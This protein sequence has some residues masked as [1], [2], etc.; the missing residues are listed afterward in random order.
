MEFT[1]VNYKKKQT[2]ETKQIDYFYYTP[3]N[4]KLNFQMF[5][6]YAEK[7]INNMSEDVAD[8]MIVIENMII[9]SPAF[10]NQETKPSINQNKWQAFK[11]KKIPLTSLFMILNKISDENIDQLVEESLQYNNF[12]LQE[13]NQLA[14]VFLGKCIMET[15]NVNVFIKY[16]KAILDNSQWYIKNNDNVFSFRDLMMDTLENE[17]NRLT[18]IA[19]HIEDVYKNQ[20]KDDNMTNELDGSEDYIKKKNIIISLINLIG[21]FYNGHIISTS[22]LVNILE[23]LK[24]Q[25]CENPQY[26]K[27]YLELFLVLWKR[28]NSNLHKHYNDTYNSYNN[29]LIIESNVQCERLKSLIE[30]SLILS[31]LTDEL[32]NIDHENCSFYEIP[33]ELN[34]MLATMN[35]SKLTKYSESVVQK[36][37]I[38]YLLEECNNNHTMLST[39]VPIIMEH[40]MDD[41][42]FIQLVNDMLEDDDIICDYPSFS[43]H[44]KEYVT[45]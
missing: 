25:Y 12:T 30:E 14:D 38:K 34:K 31:V 28:I 4:N 44:I 35:F 9:S 11:I 8:K 18:R 40:V 41:N 21:S 26:R 33:N 39:T 19:A 32:P 10:K 29:W 15:K 45:M 1:E 22:L 27:I 13:I 7:Y 43:S 42:K 5:K 24:T 16:F 20:I 17:Y 36:L 37:V 6:D 23:N 2:V 3:V